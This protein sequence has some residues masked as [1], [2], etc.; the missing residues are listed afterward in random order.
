MKLV[1]GLMLASTMGAGGL[2]LM[3]GSQP[4]GAL[5]INIQPVV[6]LLPGLNPLISIQPIID[7]PDGL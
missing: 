5:E 3:G 4:A 1:A 6:N 7:L 2:I